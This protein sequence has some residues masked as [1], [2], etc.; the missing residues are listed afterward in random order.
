MRIRVAKASDA[1]AACDVLR[2]SIAELCEL[3]HGNDQ[4]LIDRW[5]ANKTPENMASWI[6]SS[7]IFLAEEADKLLGV[8]GLT[9]SGYITLNYVAP[10]ARFRGVS[11]ALLSEMEAKA[12]ELGLRA[13]I[14]ES[15]KTATRFYR[16]AGYTEQTDASSKN[17]LS[18]SL[19]KANPPNQNRPLS[20]S[21]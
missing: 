3:D 17:V 16:A 11:K 7:H 15:T 9:D 6:A 5:L 18:K 21:N 8:A 4:V 2:R 20:G 1:A 13:C 10:E 14:L 19:G 12:T